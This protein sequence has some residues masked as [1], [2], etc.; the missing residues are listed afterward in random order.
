MSS[1]AA[2]LEML[3]VQVSML[4]EACTL[5]LAW[6]EQMKLIRGGVRVR[7]RDALRMALDNTEPPRPA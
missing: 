4:R 1:E 6:V 7:V 3:R 2:E 5:A